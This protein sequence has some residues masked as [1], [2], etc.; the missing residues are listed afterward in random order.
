MNEWRNKNSLRTYPLKKCIC[1]EQ[2]NANKKKKLIHKAKEVD[3][4]Q[5]GLTE[6]VLV[7]NTT[8]PSSKDQPAW[9]VMFTLV[10]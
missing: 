3:N 6:A 4:Q 9:N 5:Q 7:N 2:T 1:I 10:P 8:K